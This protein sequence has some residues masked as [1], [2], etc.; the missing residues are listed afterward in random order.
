[1]SWATIHQPLKNVQRI[2]FGTRSPSPIYSRLIQMIRMIKSTTYSICFNLKVK[3]KDSK[4]LDKLFMQLAIANSMFNGQILNIKSSRQWFIHYVDILKLFVMTF[5]VRNFK[6]FCQEDSLW[7]RVWKEN[8][9]LFKIEVVMKTANNG[10]PW[11]EL[12]L[13]WNYL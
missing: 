3:L 8:F 9:K 1:M 5:I 4:S 11:K 2:T 10:L 13:I 6:S 7:L 12:F